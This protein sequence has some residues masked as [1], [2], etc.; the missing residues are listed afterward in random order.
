MQQ[1]FYNSDYNAFK[2]MSKILYHVTF[3]RSDVTQRKKIHE[4]K[5][6]N[7]IKWATK[8]DKIFFG[9]VNLPK[10]STQEAQIKGMLL[11]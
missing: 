8:R 5:N 10:D 7:K 3:V 4:E 11:I 6:K 9:D 1:W 2:S